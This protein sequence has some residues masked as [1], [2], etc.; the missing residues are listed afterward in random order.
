[1]ITINKMMIQYF[2]KTKSCGCVVQALS[3]NLTRMND[4]DY[5]LLRN[6]DYI[7]I[8]EMCSQDEE[9]CIDKLHCRLNDNIFAD[10]AGNDGWKITEDV[11][12]KLTKKE[13]DYIEERTYKGV[14][15]DAMD[16]ES[17]IKK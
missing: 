10:V 17:A 6:H 5:Y 15:S 9:N 16:M 2:V 1:M 13:E 11:I 3:F 4:K 12:N 7:K 8:C 14:Y